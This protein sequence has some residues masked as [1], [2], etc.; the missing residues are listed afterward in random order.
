MNY[1][2]QQL[3]S[4]ISIPDVAT[5]MGVADISNRVFFSYDLNQFCY[6]LN[7][8]RLP[9]IVIQEMTAYYR[10]EST[11]GDGVGGTVNPSWIIR[12]MT[13]AFANRCEDNYAYL[14]R[15]KQAILKSIGNEFEF[16]LREVNMPNSAIAPIATFID[17]GIVTE[18]TFTQNFEEE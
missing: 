17:I 16:E 4:L 2:S 6:S 11:D 14:Q 18:H 5:A 12:I 9:I 8:G 13:N 1:L 3:K 7:I 10:T 15:V